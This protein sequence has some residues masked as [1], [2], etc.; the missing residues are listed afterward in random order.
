M[1]NSTHSIASPRHR[2]IQL[3][4]SIVG[5]FALDRS[6]L[7]IPHPAR[8]SDISL[9]TVLARN[10]PNRSTA[11]PSKPKFSSYDERQ[12]SGRTLSVRSPLHE[13]RAS[14]REGKAVC[15]LLIFRGAVLASVH[16]AVLR[17]AEKV[18]DVGMNLAGHAG[19]GV[20]AALAMNV[21][22]MET[23]GVVPANDLGG[24]DTP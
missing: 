8:L 2:E 24:T 1:S 6:C 7:I 11:M 5:F 19:R 22:D 12:K 20:C 23:G 4:R 21:S 14:M 18:Q 10:P 17:W 15:C 13:G 16:S 9:L 3:E